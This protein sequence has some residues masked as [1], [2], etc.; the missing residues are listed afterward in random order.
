MKTEL[1]AQEMI[2]RITMLEAGHRANE[3]EIDVLKAENA[4][5]KTDVSDLKKVVEAYENKMRGAGWLA[6]ICLAVATAIGLTF[7]PLKNW[8]A[9]QAL[10]K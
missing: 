3:K 7:E 9:A 2:E 8:L 5:L 4:S 10:K 1:S 6:G